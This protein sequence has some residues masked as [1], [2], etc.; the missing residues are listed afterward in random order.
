MKKREAGKE[1]KSPQETADLK[2]E[3]SRL[4]GAARDYLLNFV[5]SNKR[6][7]AARA[8]AASE[9]VG[10]A[11]N[12][13]SMH[14]IAKSLPGIV[15]KAGPQLKAEIE[16]TLRGFH[17]GSIDVNTVLPEQ[18]RGKIQLKVE[19]A[20]CV[21]G[22]SAPSLFEAF[23]LNLKNVSRAVKAVGDG[24]GADEKK[25]TVQP[26]QKDANDNSSAEAEERA[27]VTACSPSPPTRRPM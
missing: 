25:D 3:A 4:G 17:D 2:A 7:R 15:R 1:H 19:L 22:A 27:R 20:D 5:G 10:R 24:V 12:S 18:L 16:R 13:A 23:T 6:H 21:L 14:A 11:G 8:D 26:F 9:P